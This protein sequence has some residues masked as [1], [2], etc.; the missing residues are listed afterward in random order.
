MTSCEG[1]LQLFEAIVTS[2]ALYANGIWG[3][4][5]GAEIEKIHSRFRKHLLSMV[6]NG[7]TKLECHII[8]RGKK[9]DRKI[10]IEAR[11]TVRNTIC[12]QS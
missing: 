5:Q 2:T 8:E 10:W 4:R 11:S 1:R 3:L 7:R 12:T 6:A 9:K